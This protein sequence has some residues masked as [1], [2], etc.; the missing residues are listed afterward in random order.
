M[1]SGRWPCV[2]GVA[3]GWNPGSEEALA[4]RAKASVRAK[5][6]HPFQRVKGLF[7]Y[8]KVRHRGLMKNTQ[9]L[10][11]LFALGNLLR[12]EGQPVV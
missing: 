4:E 12:A 8:G 5:A 11:M 3:G 10:A 1:W 2:R 6:E 7:G 9:R